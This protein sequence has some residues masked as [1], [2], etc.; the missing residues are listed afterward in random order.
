MVPKDGYVP[1]AEVARPHGV[2]GEL[3]L[4]VYNQDSDLLERIR[5]AR[6]RFPDGS[7]RDV[8]IAS[9][10]PATKALLVKLAGVDDRDAAEALRGAELC[11]PRAAFPPA[12]E[13][14]FYACD[15]EG[16]RAL[17]P[18]GEEVGRVV[19]IE[20]YPTCDALVIDRGAAGRLEVP[21]VDAYVASVDVE[22][23]VVQLVT[24]EGL[25]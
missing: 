14:E 15:V 10:R 1:L 22:G 11:V 3:R 21:L 6:L 17:L 20:S 12:E 7:V 16:A 25:G 5:R 19:S 2:L 23:G 9:V 24:L 18:S 8:A 13:G 4:R